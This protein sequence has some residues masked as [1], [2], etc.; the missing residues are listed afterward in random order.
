MPEQPFHAWQ[1]LGRNLYRLGYT[2][3][4]YVTVGCAKGGGFV[5]K[6]NSTSLTR[7]FKIPHLDPFDRW[8]SCESSIKFDPVPKFQHMQNSIEWTKTIANAML[9]R[10]V[11]SFQS[12]GWKTSSKGWRVAKMASPIG[13]LE[14]APF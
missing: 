13:F 1:P 3:W 9:S 8:I 2:M 11:V 6:H 5:G 7:T 10:S 14:S 4:N 12:T